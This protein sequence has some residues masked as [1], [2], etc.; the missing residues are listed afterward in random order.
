MF[1]V[2]KLMTPTELCEMLDLP[3]A[4]TLDQWAYLGKGPAYIKVG[5]H[6]RYRVEDVEAWI[7]SQRH[8]GR[9]PW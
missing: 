1:S 2:T 9:V 7:D 8:V 6:R 3:S 5:R 4:H